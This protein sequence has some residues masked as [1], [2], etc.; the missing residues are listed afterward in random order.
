MNSV[1]V[2]YHNENDKSKLEKLRTYLMSK[3]AYLRLK[4]GAPNIHLTKGNLERLKI[5]DWSDA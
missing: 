1:K 2:I 3:D 5:P 4:E